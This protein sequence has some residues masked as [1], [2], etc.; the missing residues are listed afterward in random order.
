MTRLK[1]LLAVFVA[2]SAI[3]VGS[4]VFMAQ[5]ANAGTFSRIGNG[6]A[7][8]SL[9]NNQCRGYSK[10]DSGT[11]AKGKARWELYYSNANGGTNCFLVRNLSGG[12]H[13]MTAAISTLP[14]RG[15]WAFGQDSGKYKSYAGGVT[16]TRAAGKCVWIKG[17]Y[18]GSPF[19]IGG[20]GGFHCG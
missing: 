17:S 2:V 12:E 11:F 7:V 1:R 20:G 19:N 10:I 9:V 3:V 15:T 5:N 13:N 18:D 6:G 8:A 14:Q 16:V 4:S